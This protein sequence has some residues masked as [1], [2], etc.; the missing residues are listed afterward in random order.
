MKRF[1]P[2]FLL[3][4]CVVLL[5][6]GCR[7]AAPATEEPA[8]QEAGAMMEET[9]EQEPGS[10]IE[11]T[12]TGAS[13]RSADGCE[14][15]YSP[16]DAGLSI[17]YKTHY[18]D[19][20]NAYTYRVASN[21]G[22]KIRVEY[23]FGGEQTVTVGQEFACTAG[24]IKADGY[25]DMGNVLAGQ[26]IKLK[27]ESAEGVFMP[28][29][30]AVGTEWT[31]TYEV[32]ASSEDPSLQDL[33]KDLRQKVVV[34]NKVVGEE[35]VT[36]KAG[37]FHTFR[38]ESATEINLADAPAGGPSGVVIPAMSWLAKDVGMVKSIAG[39]QSGGTQWTVE[40]EEVGRGVSF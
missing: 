4:L 26:R 35:D 34:T 22:G 28:K 15:P 25:L 18:G 37:T 32:S 14:N 10:D 40:A 2:L 29:E 12:A 30:L 6:A 38:V 33:L 27:T 3:G 20:D 19:N 1:S 31:T 13:V 11:P 16:F 5:G 8:A 39:G 9:Q 21:Q 36:V 17:K 7:K 24:T 23:V